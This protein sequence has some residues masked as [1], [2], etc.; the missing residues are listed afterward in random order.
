MKLATMAS[1]AQDSGPRVAKFSPMQQVLGH[2][3]TFVHTYDAI[4]FTFIQM[5]DN[6][7][8]EHIRKH[9]F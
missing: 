2:F 3:Y 9:I 4:Y 7:N 5:K 1:G 8:L 6:Q